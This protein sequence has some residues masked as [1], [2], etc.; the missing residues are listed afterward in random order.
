[1]SPAASADGLAERGQTMDSAD[2]TFNLFVDC[3][4]FMP[5]HEIPA[6]WLKSYFELFSLNVQQNLSGIVF[7]NPNN[8]AR[9]Y[10]RKVLNREFAPRGGN[11]SLRSLP[12]DK[13]ERR[14][15]HMI[16]TASSL[17]ELAEFLP[18][19]QDVL[20]ESSWKLHEEPRTSISQVTFAQ[21]F[22]SQIPVIFSVGQRTLCIPSVRQSQ[23]KPP[24]PHSRLAARESHRT[25]LPISNVSLSRSS[26]WKT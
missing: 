9:R 11:S 12:A 10:L 21:V 18:N 3:T 17:T 19:Y 14:W 6:P 7:L 13:W 20:P 2:K 25:L 16:K 5:R 4:G 15:T 23:C 8:L 24:G 26:I 22:Q 1:M